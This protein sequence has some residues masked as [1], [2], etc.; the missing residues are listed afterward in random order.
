MTTAF[1][2]LPLG[3]IKP[4]GWLHDQL[5]LQADGLTGHLDEH[6]ADV[7][8]DNAWLGG[9]GDGWE[10]G[11]YYLDGLL[12]LA[13]LLEDER[14]IAKADRWVEAALASQR[15]DGSFGPYGLETSSG[16]DKSHDWWQF[17]IML[18]VLTQHA[19]A[20][21]D[22]RVL[23]F[24]ERYAEHLERELPGRP[25]EEWARARGADLVLSIRWLHARRP[26]DRWLRL[27]ELIMEQT[28][29]WAATFTEFPFRRKVTVWDPRSHGVNVAMGL[30]APAVRSL[31]TGEGTELAAVRAGLAA[32]STYHG[33]AHGL[34]S[35][36]EWL[37]GTHP[38]QGLELCA[39]VEY[40]FSMEQL[41]ATFGEG[42]FGDLLELAA[43]NALPATISA[44]WTSHQYDQQANQIAC[45][46]AD[47]P[48]SN[49][50]D[51]NLFGL[52]PH[53][54]CCTANLHQGWPKLVSHL[55]LGDHDGGL[56]AVGYAPCRVETEVAD[57][58]RLGLEVTGE[59]PFRETVGIA[60]QLD[61]PA[62]FALRLRIPGWCTAPALSING[63]PVAL[64]RR[65]RGFAVLER[66][67]RDGDRLELTLP[68]EVGLVRHQEPSVSVRRGPLIFAL[69]IAEDWRP[70]RTRE[71][72]SD[73]EV[74]PAAQWQYGID[75]DAG[76][77]VELADLPRQPFEATQAPIRLRTR[78]RL[79]RNWGLK[80]N[81]A[82]APPLVCD[83]DGQES[84]PLH[85]VPYGSARLRLTELPLLS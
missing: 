85:L 41:V 7:G 60:L 64:G 72:F 66:E 65:E 82:A 80:H 71:R 44:D 84:V 68:M 77:E 26:D 83:T 78:G 67:W 15:P 70:L 52:E 53:F 24:L 21:G 9:S 4:R 13:Y 59:Y 51:A 28:L 22:P 48:W 17:M 31:V 18:K 54:G 50:P 10:R 57:G 16:R 30:R 14:L 62:R 29:D 61:R 5:R 38:S 73:W 75:A 42:E 12:P 1:A 69:P 40:L 56:V 6:W 37:S 39:V 8:P 55:W 34:F 11:P 20:T 23:P 35:G 63:E 2:P 33:Q 58:A 36:D 25:L 81:S 47:R 79:I 45:T 49:G 43:F 3:T 27:A 76:F 74:L 32:L 19:E 46:V